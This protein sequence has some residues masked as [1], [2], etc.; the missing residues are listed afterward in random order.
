MS[1]RRLPQCVALPQAEAKTREPCVRVLK[2]GNSRDACFAPNQRSDRTA[3]A[4]LTVGVKI[5]S[6]SAATTT[7]NLSGSVF[8]N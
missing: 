8:W 1:R 2:A 6:F 5:R 4:Q 3:R 7:D